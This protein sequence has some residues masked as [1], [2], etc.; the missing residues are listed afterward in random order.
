VRDVCDIG[1]ILFNG[2]KIAYEL[3]MVG[4]ILNNVFI[5]ALHIVVGEKVLNTLS[6]HAMCTTAFGAILMVIYIFCLPPIERFNG[7]YSPANAR[8]T[9]LVECYLGW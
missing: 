6:G 3:T 1:R 8:W 5:Q 9:F 2:S 4:L 7:S